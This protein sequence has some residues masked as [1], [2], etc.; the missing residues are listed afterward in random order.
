MRRVDALELRVV[1]LEQAAPGSTSAPS[2]TAGVSLPRQAAPPTRNVLGVEVRNKRFDPANINYDKYNDHVWFDCTY[3]AVE[4]KKSTR[5]VKGVLR[6]CDLFGEPRFNLNVTLNEP[7]QPNGAVTQKGIGFEFNQFMEDHIWMVNTPVD[8]M[9]IRLDVT[10]VLY[11][12]GE[13][14][15]VG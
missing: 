9:T 5:A 8:D 2:S 14:E 6:F 4:L 12:D 10:E 13:H 7:I 11:S 3:R 1:Q 15:R